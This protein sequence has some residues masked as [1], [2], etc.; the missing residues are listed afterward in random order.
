MV[1]HTD[2][3]IAKVLRKP[4]LARRMVAWPIELSK[5]SIGYEPRGP[6][7][8]Q[9]LTNFISELHPLTLVEESH[10]VVYVDRSQNY[11]GSG[12]ESY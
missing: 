12:L 2:Y 3:P 7:K 6:I 5:F 4:K 11:L 9:W 10:W 8:A 1:V